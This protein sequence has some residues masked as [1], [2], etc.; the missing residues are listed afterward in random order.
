MEISFPFYMIAIE[1]SNEYAFFF[2][3]QQTSLLFHISF[4]IL[5]FTDFKFMGQ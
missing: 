4:Y 3:L 1:P 5:N 2:N